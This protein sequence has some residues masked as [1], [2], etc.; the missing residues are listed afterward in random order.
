MFSD[1]QEEQ[2]NKRILAVLL[3]L[4]M[5]IGIT[6]CGKI[7]ISGGGTKDITLLVRGNLDAVYP[8]TFD[9]DYL[10]LVGTDE[11]SAEADYVA[12]LESE[13]EYFCYYFGIIDSTFGEDF[14]DI[15][16]DLQK[17]LVQLYRDIYSKSRYECKEAV[18]QEDGN[19][20]VQ[21]LIDPID[22]IQ[23]CYDMIVS[24]SYQPWNEFNTK[25][26][27]ADLSDPAVNAEYIREKA[28]MAIDLVNSQLPNLGYQ[29]QKS[30][31]V[32]VQKDEEGYYSINS[33][34]WTMIDLYMVTYP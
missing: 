1:S 19:Y 11:A 6:A 28:R 9:P 15:P 33:D 30:L 8:G 32:Q 25:Y 12:G 31:S 10:D 17:E 3:A 29:D 4:V 22:V 2:M 24:D 14:S 16:E 21:V 34:D 27:D 7:D 26:N 18:E 5:V 13:A 23:T 20:T